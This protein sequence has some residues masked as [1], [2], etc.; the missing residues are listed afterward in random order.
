MEIPLTGFFDLRWQACKRER[1][2]YDN[3]TYAD[4]VD[5]R[6]SFISQKNRWLVDV[7]DIQARIVIEA[8]LL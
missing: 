3:A 8:G 7:K 5:R 4:C 2:I 1:S 6:K